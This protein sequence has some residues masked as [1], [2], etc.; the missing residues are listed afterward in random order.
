VTRPIQ[1]GSLDAGLIAL[2]EL[3]ASQINGCLLC[4]QHGLRL[5][6]RCA[7]RK[8]TVV[9]CAFSTACASRC[10]LPSPHRRSSISEAG[11]APMF[12]VMR[13]RPRWPGPNIFRVS[14][15]NRRPMKSGRA[16]G[17][18]STRR[19]SQSCSGTGAAAHCGRPARSSVVA[20]PVSRSIPL[21][22]GTSNSTRPFPGQEATCFPM[23]SSRNTARS[24]YS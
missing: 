18:T 13:R 5:A 19:K 4:V 23:N 17:S 10:K 16:C 3:R 1:C 11:G 22:P 8:S 21:F 14:A 20:P 9:C 6:L 7:H 2:L 24:S 12:S 15:N